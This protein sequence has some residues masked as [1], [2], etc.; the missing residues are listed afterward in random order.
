MAGDVFFPPALVLLPSPA[1]P[2]KEV[3]IYVRL[4]V[5]RLFLIPF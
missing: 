3:T 4:I 5:L 1:D 2:L